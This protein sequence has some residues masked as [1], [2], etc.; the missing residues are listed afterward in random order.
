MISYYIIEEREF[1]LSNTA[2]TMEGAQLKAQAL[3]DKSP[4]SVFVVA[5]P[6]GR[7]TT[8]TSFINT[9]NDKKEAGHP[10]QFESVNG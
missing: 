6:S 10:C 4:G 1:L 2:E 8:T 9:G 3:A 5:K 7:F